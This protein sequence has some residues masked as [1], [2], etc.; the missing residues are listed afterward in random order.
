[1]FTVWALIDFRA[2]CAKKY[3][4]KVFSISK[5]EGGGLSK[6][7]ALCMFTLSGPPSPFNTSTL[8]HV[9]ML[10]STIKNKHIQDSHLYLLLPHLILLKKFCPIWHRRTFQPS[11][12]NILYNYFVLKM[13]HHKLWPCH[14]ILQWYFKHY[15]WILNVLAKCRPL[16]C[17]INSAVKIDVTTYKVTSFWYAKLSTTVS[18]WVTIC[19][20]W[21]L[22]YF[23]KLVFF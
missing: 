20:L 5:E 9:K 6:I 13:H 12:L 7:W 2:K 18:Q 16:C 1:M 15:W 21:S 4:P 19:I 17:S 22:R 3:R 10:E 23:F 8:T 11:F 14:L